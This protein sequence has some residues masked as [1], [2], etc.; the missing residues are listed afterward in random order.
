[1]TLTLLQETTATLLLA[2]DDF[3]LLENSGIPG[4]KLATRPLDELHIEN[5]VNSDAAT[6]EP[7]KATHTDK[8]YVLYGGRHRLE[9]AKIKGASVLKAESHSFANEKDIVRAAFLDNM[10]HGLKADFETRG[11]FAY[12][13][14]TNYPGIKQEEIKALTG[15]AQSTISEAIARQEKMLRDEQLDEKVKKQLDAE[16]ICKRFSKRAIKFLAEVEG[17]R[18]EEV[19]KYI[20]QSIGPDEREKLARV[21]TLLAHAYGI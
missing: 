19:I 17:M 9:A 11:K 21:A 6:W 20:Q 8:G 4:G 12:F 18:D 16:E 3:I 7:V 10:N 2:L 13:L 1:M 5:L 15:L 14:F